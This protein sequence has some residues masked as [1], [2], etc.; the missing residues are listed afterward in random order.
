[1]VRLSV[2]LSHTTRIK[3]SFF[4]CSAI[5]SRQKGR[6]LACLQVAQ[7]VR[8]F[9]LFVSLCFFFTLLTGEL[10]LPSQAQDLKWNQKVFWHQMLKKWD[11]G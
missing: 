4:A 8:H 6:K 11:D 1:M 2:S 5:H 10:L 9:S 7:H 3:H